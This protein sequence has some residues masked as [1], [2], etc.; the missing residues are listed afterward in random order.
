MGTAL[1]F[2][3][4]GFDPGKA[5]RLWERLEN[6]AVRLDRLLSR[7]DPESEVYRLNSGALASPGKEIAGLIE[8][9]GNYRERTCGL[10]D[11]H[12]DGR[13]LDF[14]GFAK[15]W[16]L[17]LCLDALRQEGVRNAF[18]DFGGSAILALGA[19]PHGDCW[20][21]SV[22]NPYDGS[23]LAE[24]DLKDTALS[25][26]GN[27]P[28]YGGHILNPLTGEK[29]TARKLVTVRSAD[30]LEAEVLSTALMAADE[31]RRKIIEREFPGAEIE[32]YDL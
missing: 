15:G 4:A 2:L 19:H 11:I 6:E 8:M 20:K 31:S 30:P 24:T 10:F 27:S 25:T 14:G 3:T 18:V 13:T 29:V 5:S 26:S 22:P 17:T 16:F 23:I 7:F 21:V 9:A 12:P 32:I 1:E 28:L